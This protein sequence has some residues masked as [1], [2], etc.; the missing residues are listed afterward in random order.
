M[1]KKIYAFGG[2]TKKGNILIGNHK[3]KMFT[4]NIDNDFWYRHLSRFSYAI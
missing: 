3:S 2:I 4:Y 1:G